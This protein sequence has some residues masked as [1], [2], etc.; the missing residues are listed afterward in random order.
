LCISSNYIILILPSPLGGKGG[1]FHPH[2]Y[3][4]PS[5]GR[6]IDEII[7]SSKRRNIE[8]I[9]FNNQF[10]ILVNY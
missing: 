5:R 7:L 3:P 6:N 8:N 10:Y 9:P 2:L 4:P 1:L